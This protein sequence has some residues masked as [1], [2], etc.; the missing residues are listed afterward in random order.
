MQYNVVTKSTPKKFKMGGIMF[1]LT[2]KCKILLFCALILC[3]FQLQSQAMIV[4]VYAQGLS[5]SEDMRS[6]AKLLMENMGTSSSSGS[7]DSILKANNLS[8][9]IING[10][11]IPPQYSIEAGVT[12]YFYSDEPFDLQG[13]EIRGGNADFATKQVSSSIIT[14]ALE[15]ISA[16]PKKFNTS[17]KRVTLNRNSLVFDYALSKGGG[18]S[19]DIIDVK[20]GLLGHWNWEESSSGDFF[21]RSVDVKNIRSPGTCFVRWESGNVRVV[22]KLFVKS[23]K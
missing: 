22:Q 21:R 4:M 1:Y 2:R 20:G 23:N 8:F 10:A 13:F 17:L 16:S 12:A 9:T 3:A 5:V 11:R 14:S 6:V 7:E 18:I 15:K 19:V